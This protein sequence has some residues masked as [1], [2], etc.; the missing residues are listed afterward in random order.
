M[1][2]MLSPTTQAL[3]IGW[4]RAS[5]AARNRSGSGLA[6]FDLVTGDDRHR[7]RVNAQ[8]A[9]QGPGR[10]HSPAGRNCP[11]QARLG[12]VSQK[13]PGAGQRADLAS[14]LPVGLGMELAQPLDPLRLDRQ[15]GPRKSMLVNR[16][17]DMPIRRGGSARPRA[18]SPL[19]LR[20]RARR[21]HADRHCR[22][23]CDRGR[24]GMRSGA[25]ASSSSGAIL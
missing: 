8:V 4:P 18:R 2:Q 23:G 16:P 13:L 3:S 12:Q 9:E 24:T 21:A 20:P 25:R 22:R 10:L 1:S 7:H 19:P 6:Y 17:P 15:S 14:A 5:A 11:R